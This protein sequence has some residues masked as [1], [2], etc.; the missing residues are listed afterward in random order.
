V[1]EYPDAQSDAATH[2]VLHGEPHTPFVPAPPHVCPVGQLPQLI[3]SP[4]PSVVMPQL[5]PCLVQVS[6]AQ[7][8]DPVV[9]VPEPHT[10][11][12]PPPPHVVPLE[13]RPQF[14]RPPHPSLTVP[15][16]TPMLAHVFGAHADAQ[17]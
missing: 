6:G 1:Q 12:E 10:P 8:V 5:K 3:S 7:L 16:L 2:V 4:Q 9:P 13:H 11:P 14:K 17:K 15:Q